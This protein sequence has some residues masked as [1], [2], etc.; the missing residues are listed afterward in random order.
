MLDEIIRIR[1][2]SNPLFATTTKTK[3]ILKGLD[4]GKFNSGSAD[5]PVMIGKVIAAAAEMGIFFKVPGKEP[6]S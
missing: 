3:L 2:V 4:P 1:S 5:D 6:Q